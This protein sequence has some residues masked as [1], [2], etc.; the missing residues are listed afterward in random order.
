ML[1]ELSFYIE[2]YLHKYEYQRY[3]QF[4]CRNRSVC[5]GSEYR[6]QYKSLYDIGVVQS[7]ADIEHTLN[8]YQLKLGNL[9]MK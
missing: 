5:A 2:D 7:F 3:H 9:L 6:T 4:G 1:K 8:F